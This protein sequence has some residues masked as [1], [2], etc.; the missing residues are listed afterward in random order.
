[1]AEKSTAAAAIGLIDGRRRQA[2][3]RAARLA[4]RNHIFARDPWLLL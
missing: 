4:Q 2:A 3:R 1:M